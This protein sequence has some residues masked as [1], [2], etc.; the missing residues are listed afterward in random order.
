[1]NKDTQSSQEDKRQFKRV[2]VPGL[3][4][5]F[6]IYDL[7]AWSNYLDRTLESIQNISMGGISFRSDQDLAIKA[8]L[9]LD[10]RITPEQGPIK[11]FGRVAWIKKNKENDYDLGVKFSWWDRE[12]DKKAL[13][14][15]IQ[16]HST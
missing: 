4:V 6:K 16:Q 7:R 5:G 8:P 12:E 14:D 2:N 15:L 13:Y 10:I 11:T 1:M 3:K 9:G